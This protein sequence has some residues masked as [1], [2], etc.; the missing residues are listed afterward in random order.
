MSENEGLRLV[1]VALP[2]LGIGL[3]IGIGLIA[4]KRKRNKS[5]DDNGYGYDHDQF[6]GNL[7]NKKNP[8]RK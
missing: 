6:E 7:N 5:N 3:I 4:G 2:I 8:N 1:D